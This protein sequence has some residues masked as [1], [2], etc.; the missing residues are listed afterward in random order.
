MPTGEA[1]FLSRRNGTLALRVDT[2]GRWSFHWNQVATDSA[3]IADSA[4]LDTTS[5]HHLAAT[6][7]GA[8]AKLFVDHVLRATA[9]LPTVRF[10]AT[11]L[12]VG[13][14]GRPPESAFANAVIDDV[15]LYD[16]ALSADEIAR[17]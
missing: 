4:P 14:N 6:H 13:G 12:D 8:T 10:D 5:W 15:R 3:K 7:D 17:L 11:G 9:A 1:R 16:R 2:E